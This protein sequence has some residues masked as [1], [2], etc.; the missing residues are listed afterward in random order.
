MLTGWKTSVAPILISLRDLT[1]SL[2]AMSVVLKSLLGA[3]DA[4]VV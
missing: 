3:T 2:A 4:V 1:L